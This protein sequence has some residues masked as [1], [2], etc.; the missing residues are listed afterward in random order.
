MNKKSTIIYVLRI[1]LRIF[2]LFPIKKNGIVFLSFSGKQYSCN[3]KYIFEYLKLRA[4][5]KL[6]FIWAFNDVERH[7]SLFEN[8]TVTLCRTNSIQ[9]FYYMMTSQIIISNNL[10]S[11][12]FPLRK[13]QVYIETWHGGGAYKK[14]GESVYKN[15]A[16]RNTMRYIANM[17]TAFISSSRRVTITK[18]QGHMIPLEK[19]WECGMPR[20]DL[21][22]KQQADIVE[23]VRKVLNIDDN[24]KLVLYAPTFRSSKAENQLYCELNIV[25]CAQA[26]SQRFGG[27]WVFLFRTHH[28]VSSD[29]TIRNVINVSDYDDMQELL[30]AADVLITDYSSCMWDFS[31][32]NK[33]CFVF[34]PDKNSYMH[35]RDFFTPMNEWPYP[36]AEN[37]EELESEILLFNESE[38]AGKINEHHNAAGSFELGHATE[39]VANK[40]MDFIELKSKPRIER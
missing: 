26:L 23:K 15:D 16:E 4:G 13:S 12:F 6:K 27:E 2:Y 19:F 32:T 39:F 37:N 3:P 29:I 18:S 8:S 30:C 10:V 24:L 35:D 20:N 7:R 17:M 33:P 38:Y 1:L 9:Y 36:I 28:E 31:L 14:T 34:A 40:I 21:F 11:S 22:F 25:R 5:E